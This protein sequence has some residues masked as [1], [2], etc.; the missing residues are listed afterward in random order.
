MKTVINKPKP[1]VSFR[2]LAFGLGLL[3]FVLALVVTPRDK[4]LSA[5]KVALADTSA[6]SA[7]PVGQNLSPAAL[8]SEYGAAVLLRAFLPQAGTP[9]VATFDGTDGTTCQPAKTEFKLGQNVCATATNT[10]G[11]AARRRFSWVDP[12]GFVRQQTSIT[13]D[14]QDDHFAIPSDPTTTLSNGQVVTN[15]G[16][17]RVNIISSRGAPVATAIF[18]VKDP[19]NATADLLV[20][21][22][23]PTNSEQ[24]AAGSNGSFDIIVQNNGPDD[25][26]TV[27]VT[28]HVPDNTTFV[29]MI[30]TSGQ[31]STSFTCTTVPDG[32]GNITCSIA[33]FAAGASATFDFVYT[34]SIASATTNEPYPSNNS[35][36]ASATVSSVGGNTGVCTMHCPD[37]I[38]TPANTTDP[39]DPNK[40]GAVVHFT[41]PSG[42]GTC[43]TITV[44]HCN[45]CFFP[46]GTTKVT[47]TATTGDSCSF[48]V[49]VTPAGVT[50]SCPANQTA[51]ADSNCSATVN[52]GTATATGDNVT[53][54][55]TRSDGRPMYTC[56]VNGTNC[57]RRTSDDPFPAGVTTITWI[58]YAHDTPGPYASLTDEEAHRTGSASCTQTVTVNDVTPPVITP[59]PDQTASADANCQAAVPDFTQSTTV[60]DNC[61]CA[62]SDTS[63]TCQGRQRITVTQ[64]PAP[65]TMV[66]LGAHDIKL[67]ANDG[68]SNNNGAGNTSTAHMT[69]TVKDT[70]APTITC[71]ADMTTNTLPGTC[72]A[73]V[74]VGV[75]T[76]SDN[77]DTLVV[78]TGTRSDGQSILDPLYPKGTTTI[79][80]TAT[81][82]SGNQSSCTQTITVVDNEPPTITFNGQT[83][84][85]WPPNHSYHTFTAADFISSVSDNCDTLSVSDVDIIMATSDEPENAPGSGNTLNDIVI[86]SN[87]KSIQLRAERVASGNGRVYTITFRLRDH[88]G[89]TTTG[90]AKVYSPR[91]Q[92]ETPGDD[93]PHYTV[94]GNCP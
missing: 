55:A 31:P 68:S 15:V 12:Q 35:A 64:D 45:D 46:L 67:T 57:T 89:N 17:W 32:L 74:I 81:D 61:S 72:S 70:T 50:I 38:V 28:D 94:T 92:G 66:G 90:T 75:A 13:T 88:S 53:V 29:A 47:A 84:S 7:W 42:E 18:V 19:H 80:W 3:V 60:T 69:F 44:D 77:C 25:A 86:A 39:N 65:G 79:T 16:N 78:P 34:A 33:S 56:D 5:D 63:D 51:D 49:T 52:V 91:N 37:D 93:G 6:S 14:P 41:P 36:T 10:G 71:P 73:V 59:P 22:R 43:G 30:Q 48:T 83:P 1:S 54:I 8:G 21:K 20:S 4:A 40:R 9:S 26:A 24:V 76:A 2:K 23:A 87:C 82:A 11:A 62:A 58:A 85:M 27:T